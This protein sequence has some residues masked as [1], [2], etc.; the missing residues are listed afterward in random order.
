MT[1]NPDPA[2]FIRPILRDY[3]RSTR[4]IDQSLSETSAIVQIYAL[5]VLEEARPH[6][7]QECID[8]LDAL[9]DEYDPTAHNEGYFVKDGIGMA[10]SALVRLKR[11]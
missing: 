8:L 5:R 11:A 3:A 7:Y 6:I 10:I 9:Y 2:D 4:P 1:L